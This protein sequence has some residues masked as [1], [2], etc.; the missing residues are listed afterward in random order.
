MQPIRSFSSY[1]A[2]F[3][4]IMKWFIVL[5]AVYLHRAPRLIGSLLRL[6][7]QGSSGE[8]EESWIS[9]SYLYRGLWS[10]FFAVVFGTMVTATISIARQA[11]MV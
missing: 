9:V 1:T 5:Y 10:V 7:K 11:R 4:S 2:F 8:E 3:F 6:P